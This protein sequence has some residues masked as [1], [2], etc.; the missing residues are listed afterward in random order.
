[1]FKCN[2]SQKKKKKNYHKC[3]PCDI[4]NYWLPEIFFFKKK[5]DMVYIYQPNLD[6]G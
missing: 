4:S 1:M 3:I 5:I 2:D 6:I